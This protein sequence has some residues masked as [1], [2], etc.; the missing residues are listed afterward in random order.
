MYWCE[1]TCGGGAA[2]QPGLQPGGDGGE[3]GEEA[4]E[5]DPRHLYTAPWRGGLHQGEQKT[6][7]TKFDF[8]QFNPGNFLRDVTLNLM[9]T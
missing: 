8:L 7:G 2:G 1:S 9:G 5:E 6:V 4:A 3:V